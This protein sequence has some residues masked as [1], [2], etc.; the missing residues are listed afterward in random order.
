MTHILIV[1]WEY[2]GMNSSQGQ[3]LVRRIGQLLRGFLSNGYKVTFL[4]HDK[5]N[6]TQDKS[7]VIYTEGNLTRIAVAFDSQQKT[8]HPLFRKFR[9]FWEVATRGDYTGN[10]ANAC[11]KLIGS[12]MVEIQRPHAILAFSSPKGPI[13]LA[14]VLAKK[15][16]TKYFVDYQD[17]YFEGTGAGLIKKISDYWT[18]KTLKQ[19]TEVTIINRFWAEQLKTVYEKKITVLDHAIPS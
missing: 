7:H 2:P 8:S 19:C 12:E 9:T 16:K 3:A 14:H 10:W 18:K 13:Y 5:K 15:F 6:E 11:I 4:H 17:P 1:A